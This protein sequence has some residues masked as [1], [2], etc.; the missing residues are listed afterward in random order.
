ML[1]ETLIENGYPD[2]FIE[3]YFNPTTKQEPVFL[4]PKKTVYLELL[5][6]G[7]DVM[8]LIKSRLAAAI[9]RTDNAA[10][11][12]LLETTTTLPVP[13]RKDPV[14]KNAKSNVIYQFDCICGS[15]YIGRTQRHLETRIK[16]HIPRW[17]QQSRTGQTNSAISKHLFETRHIVNPQD[18]FKII[19]MS[20]KTTLLPIAEAVA[21]NRFKPSLCLQKELVRS[22][23][24]SW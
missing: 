3:K 16:E 4:A 20:P 2:K 9:K 1:K 14:P 24:L 12:L 6:K 19:F 10:Q 18:S 8:T 21:I 23:S 7:D 5:F 11:L 22:L 17:L 13:P 15:R